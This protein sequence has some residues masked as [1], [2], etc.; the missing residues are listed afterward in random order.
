MKLKVNRLSWDSD[1]WGVEYYNCEKFDIILKKQNQGS[2]FEIKENTFF[3]VLTDDSDLKF[4][5]FLED[6]GF[7]FIENKIKLIKN[8]NTDEHFTLSHCNRFREIRINELIK[9]KDKFSNLFLNVSRFS[10]F[11]QNKVDLFYYKWVLNSIEN[12]NNEKCI[13]IYDGQ[14]LQGFVTYSCQMKSVKIGLMAVFSEFQGLGLSRLLL[15]FIT[16]IAKSLK[17]KKIIV[18]TQGKNIKG[19]KSY[20]RNGFNMEQIQQWYYFY[21]KIDKDFTNGEI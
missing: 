6:S 9:V 8:I 16:N 19:L 18:Y 3:Q 4:I 13:G 15:E 12:I 11:S 7:R 17:Y 21:K 2:D 14:T 1:F 10:C 20:Q 5:H